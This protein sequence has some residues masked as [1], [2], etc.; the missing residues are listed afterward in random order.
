M[1]HLYYRYLAFIYAL[2]YRTSHRRFFGFAIGWWVK[3]L[4][5]GLLLMIWTQQWERGVLVLALLLSGWV[6]LVYWRA[7]RV[8][9]VKFIAEPKTSPTDPV[10][11]SANQR[12]P[13]WATGIFIVRDGGNYRLLN[14][15]EYWQVPLGDHIVMVKLGPER[16]AYQFFNAAGLLEV[17]PGSL[18]FGTILR[19]TLAVTILETYQA[20][21]PIQFNFA[22]P[23]KLDDL[24]SKKRVL[25]FTFANAEIQR[26]VWHNLVHD[27]QRVRS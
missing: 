14:P 10:P 1:K 9:Y 11:L 20:I 3:L 5:L 6:F 22:D 16:Y 4:A 23:D 19:H 2:T 8:G 21:E 15:A 18:L 24:P 12:V 7:H 17:Q 25:Y 27:A 13:M 26:A